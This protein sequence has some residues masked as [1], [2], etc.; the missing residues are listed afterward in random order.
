MKKDKITME[1]EMQIQE[2]LEQIPNLQGEEKT[3]LGDA[4][5]SRIRRYCDYRTFS[6]DCRLCSSRI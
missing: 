3:T 6:L 5:E 4:R 2:L 1:L